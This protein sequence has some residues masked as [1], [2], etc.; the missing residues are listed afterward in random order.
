MHRVVLRHRPSRGSAFVELRGE[1]RAWA[2][3][4]PLRRVDDGAFEAELTLPPGQRFK[5]LCSPTIRPLFG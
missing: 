2:D 3:P 5:R 1:V 4:V